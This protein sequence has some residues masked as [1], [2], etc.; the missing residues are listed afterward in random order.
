MKDKYKKWLLLPLTALG[1]YLYRLR[2]GGPGPNLP[3]PLDQI[4]FSSFPCM[5]LPAIAFWSTHTIEDIWWA[6]AC[7]TVMIWAVAWESKG[8]GGGMDLATSPKEPGEGRTLETIEHLIYPWLFNKVDRYTYDLVL[9]T[10]TGLVVTLMPGIFIISTGYVFAGT[11]LA[12]SGGLKGLGYA[13]GWA[14]FNNTES[15]EWFTGGLRWLAAAL[16][17]ILFI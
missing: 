6:V 17:W 3:R 8:H 2:G 10:L 1:A 5:V 15:G 14:I 4:L 12:L 7:L 9:I 13:A 16:I 11:L